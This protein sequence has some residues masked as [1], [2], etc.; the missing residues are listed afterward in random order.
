M[1]EGGSHT[2]RT[3]GSTVTVHAHVIQVCVCVQ[4]DDL[5][6]T[7]KRTSNLGE[8]GLS[9]GPSLHATHT[10]ASHYQLHP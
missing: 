10:K 6:I 5:I 2:I 8:M 4:R 1:G 9:Q 3:C 7:N